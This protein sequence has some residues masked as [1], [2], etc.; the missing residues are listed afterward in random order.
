VRRR[1]QIAGAVDFP[2]GATWLQPAILQRQVDLPKKMDS[3]KSN[4]QAY[5]YDAHHADDISHE[6]FF[7]PY[8]LFTQAL[9]KH[10][11][12]PHVFRIHDCSNTK[13]LLCKSGN[14][15]ILIKSRERSRS[16]LFRERDCMR[17]AAMRQP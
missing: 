17:C 6:S 9:S 12:S 2:V 5:G 14:G 7:R 10:H 8:L 13:N 11:G 1:R 3:G 15:S 16:G 4:S